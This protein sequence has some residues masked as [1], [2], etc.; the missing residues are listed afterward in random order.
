VEIT[1]L[2]LLEREGFR[3]A[4]NFEYAARILEQAGM[5]NNIASS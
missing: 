5:E 2:E 1:S 4:F 3:D